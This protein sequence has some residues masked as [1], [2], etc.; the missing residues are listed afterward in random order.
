MESHRKPT[1]QEKRLLEFLIKQS[2]V[3]IPYNWEQGLL[4]RTMDDGGMGSLYLFYEGE[5][6]K[7]R[8]FGKQVS[9]FQFKDADGVDVIASLNLDDIGVLFELDI[10]KTDFGKLLKLPD[11]F[12]LSGHL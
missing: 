2:S 1:Q 7:D 4:V 3:N 8:K 11:V 10:W 12:A 9:E 5:D 6:I